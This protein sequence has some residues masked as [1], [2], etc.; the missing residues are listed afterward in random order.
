[1]TS[2]IGSPAFGTPHTKSKPIQASSAT[3]KSSLA[4]ISSSPFPIGPGLGLS[5]VR[6]SIYTGDGESFGFTTSKLPNLIAPILRS[7]IARCHSEA[8]HF[9]EILGTDELITASPSHYLKFP[10]C[11]R[12]MRQLL[13]LKLQ[14]NLCRLKRKE[15]RAKN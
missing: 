9:T 14:R 3:L 1:M 4:I 7:C 15:F 11:Y 6:I 5:F 8:S 12:S 10:K 13:P 2:A